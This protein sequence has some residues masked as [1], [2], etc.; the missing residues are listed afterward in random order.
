MVINRVYLFHQSSIGLL[1]MGLRFGQ[2]LDLLVHGLG[3]GVGEDP[4][5]FA[6]GLRVGI[7]QDP[8]PLDWDSIEPNSIRA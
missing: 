6:H 4:D 8:N 1:S 3:A 5:L 7:S 2:D